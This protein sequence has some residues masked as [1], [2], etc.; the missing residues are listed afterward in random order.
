MELVNTVGKAALL[1]R[2]RVV[3]AFLI[4]LTI[5]VSVSISEIFSVIGFL[6]VLLEWRPEAS[7]KQ[8]AANPVAWAAVTLFAVLG[9]GTLYS[10]VPLPE[11]LRI[12]GK[13]RELLYLPLFMLLCRDSAARRAGLY[14]FL[15][16]VVLILAVGSTTL[17]PPLAR[18]V[19]LVI[20]RVPFESAFGSYIS[21]GMMVALGTYFFAVEAVLR[22][23]RR[24]VFVALA[25]WAL[26]YGLFLNTGRTGYIVLVALAVILLL[27]LA[28]RRFWLPGAAVVLA[29]AGTLMYLSPRMHERMAGVG[30]ALQ[31]E[32][33]S[34][35]STSAGARLQYLQLG[36]E[37][38][39]SHPVLGT[40]TGS[41]AATYATLAAQHDYPPA[42]NPHN[43]YVM[44]GVQTG[45]VGLIALFGFFAVL[46]RTAGRLPTWDARRAQALTLAF[47]VACLFNSLLLDHKDGHNFAFLVALFFSGVH[48]REDQH[49]HHD[50]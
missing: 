50:L 36:G 30:Q 1:D 18:L 49:R 19:G 39:L 6:I 31:G 14:G 29:V 32:G 16:A 9:L 43:E 12:W 2:A 40:G 15:G 28:P 4:G 27:Q 11:A 46:W 3:V 26:L 8:L 35:A 13:Y 42:G 20:G 25:A 5:P 41:F 10:A 33:S 23:E 34:Y 48:R 47:V 7:W 38:F 45:A 24:K 37:A 21:E 44:I 17:Y 22:P